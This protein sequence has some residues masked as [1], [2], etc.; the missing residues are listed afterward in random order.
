MPIPTH[1]EVH[2]LSDCPPETP[3]RRRV[4]PHR[5]M[6][7]K[8]GPRQGSAFSEIEIERGIPPSWRQLISK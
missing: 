7:K 6:G 8:V 4:E 3:P 5:G 1:E 2:K